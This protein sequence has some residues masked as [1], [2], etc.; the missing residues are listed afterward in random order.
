MFIDRLY[1]QFTYDIGIDLGTATTLVAVRG[2]DIIIKEPSV[3]ALNK[4]TGEIL[5]VGTEAKHMIGRTPSHIVAISPLEDGVINDFGST[6]AMIR[7]FINRIHTQFPKWYLLQRPRVVIGIPSKITEVEV[8]A[9]VDAAKS[10]GARKVYVIEEPMAAAIG[11][12]LPIENA[13]GSMVV[14][15]GG[16]TT[17]IAIISLGGIVV[18]NSIKIA[19]NEMDLA[20]VDYIKQ[21]YN[22]LIGKKM[23][24]SLKIEIGTAIPSKIKES[25]EIKGRE[26]LSGLPRAVEITSNEVYEAIFPILNKI[27]EATKEAVEKTPPEIISDLLDRGIYLTGGGALIRGLDQF[28][29]KNLRIPVIVVDDPVSCVV[30]GTQI[31]LDEIDLLEKIKIDY[32]SL[33]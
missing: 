32:V 18:D 8:K 6:E 29:Q 17:D 27:S 21:K 30:R 11:A 33:L 4:Q 9:V 26:L 19:G 7:Y 5:A 15:I 24:E 22:I 13:L 2:K 20:I 28:L 3:V 12:A 23:A 14:D 16:G 25:V 10:A 1:S 31:L